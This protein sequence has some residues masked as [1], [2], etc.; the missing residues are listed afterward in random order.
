MSTT[1]SPEPHELREYHRKLCDEIARID[2]DARKLGRDPA[3]VAPHYRQLCSELKTATQ[4]IMRLVYVVEILGGGRPPRRMEG[5]FDRLQAESFVDSFN[6]GSVGTDIRAVA[7][8]L[9]EDVNLA[10]HTRRA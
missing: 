6:A 1:E 8:E 9:T 7:K 3:I 10:R 2:R 4:K 5:L